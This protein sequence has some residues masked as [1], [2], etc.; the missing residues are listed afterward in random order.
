MLYCDRIEVSA[1]T[2]VNMTSKSKECEGLNFNEMSAMDA[3]VY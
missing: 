2:D 3:M 1:G